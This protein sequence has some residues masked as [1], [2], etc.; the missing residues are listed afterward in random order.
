MT[1]AKQPALVVD[2]PLYHAQQWYHPGRTFPPEGT[3]VSDKDLQGYRDGG[4]L[5]TRE[6]LAK[7]ENPRAYT[8]EEQRDRAQARVEELEAQLAQQSGGQGSGPDLT[9]LFKALDP[10]G[11]VTDVPSAVERATYMLTSLGRHD[12]IMQANREYEDA[13]GPLLPADYPA[14]AELIKGGYVTVNQVAQAT[15]AELDDVDGVAKKKIEAIRAV[16]PHQAAAE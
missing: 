10:N 7:R 15:D 16:T 8:A 11:D 3:T 9:E 13:F 2:K 6:D 14:R 12:Q 4:Y 5:V 1:E